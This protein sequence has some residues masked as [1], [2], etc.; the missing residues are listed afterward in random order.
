MYSF[1]K[2]IYFCI[3]VKDRKYVIPIILLIILNTIIELVGIG[4]FIPLINIILSPESYDSNKYLIHLSNNSFLSS[5]NI[6]FILL[7][8][9]IIF[10][11]IRFFF[12]TFYFI[13]IQK[14]LHKVSL[15]SSTNLLNI[16]MKQPIQ[17]SLKSKPSVMFKNMYTEMN[18]IRANV[19]LM[20]R[21]ISDI[22]LATCILSIL[23]FF[24]PKITI[25]AI[26]FLKKLCFKTR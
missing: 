9:N 23:I 24:N 26:S 19:H 4:A 15:N 2:K 14:F 8:L 18:T 16:Y 11:I 10:F 5:F 22:I 21:F 12:K 17:L 7:F 20:V 3:D 13:I 1:F 6:S 25:L